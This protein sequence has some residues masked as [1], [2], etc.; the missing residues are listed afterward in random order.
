MDLTP[1]QARV[2]RDAVRARVNY[3]HGVRVRMY[4]LRVPADDPLYRLFGEAEAVLTRLATELHNR[5]IVVGDR[6]P[7]ESGGSPD[8]GAVGPGGV[9][10][11]A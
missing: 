11:P 4:Q 1:D 5:S 6:R 10:P 3:L 2:L 9:P 8:D 7:W